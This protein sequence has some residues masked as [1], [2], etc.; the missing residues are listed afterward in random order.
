MHSDQVEIFSKVTV[1]GLLE[2][3]D[4]DIIPTSNAIH[5]RV[6]N[7]VTRILK[8]NEDIKEVSDRNWKISVVNDNY[9]ENAMVV[10]SGHIFVFTGILNKCKNDDQLAII[11]GHEIAHSLLDHAAEN[12]NFQSFLNGCLIIPMAVLLAFIPSIATFFTYKFI[13]KV[14]ELLY[15]LPKSRLMENEADEVGLKLAANACYDIREA[16]VLWGTL[17][18]QKLMYETELDQAYRKK[19][20][21]LGF[22]STHPSNLSR[23]QN[24]AVLMPEMLR[25]RS[26]QGCCSL[27]KENPYENFKKFRN[28]IK[29]HQGTFNYEWDKR[30][31]LRNAMKKQEKKDEYVADAY[32]ENHTIVIKVTKKE[33]RKT[34]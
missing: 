26:A 31:V 2:L 24:V 15:E 32:T 3:H 4:K 18:L 1:D 25:I 33:D 16:P 5:K 28:M 12:M 17:H 30:Q 21:T 14:T 23:E 11:L 8:S 34:L 9:T 22:L 19:G 10:P 20:V 6:E 29:D 27:P 13:D 7:V